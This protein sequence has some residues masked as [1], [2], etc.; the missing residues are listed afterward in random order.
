[1]DQTEHPSRKTWRD[2]Q[3][4]FWLTEE[5]ARGEGSYLLSEQA[6]A[7][8][9]DI[10]AAFCAGAWIAAIV[11][12]TAAMDA[13]LREV[14]L[15]GFAGNTKAL[16]DATTS[17]PRLHALRKRRN[18]LVHVDPEEPGITVDQQWANRPAL[19]AEARTAIELMFEVFYLSPGT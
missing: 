17:D 11:L 19:E 13:V 14:E 16:V 12:S 2:R 5:L 4:W 1:M 7:L 8:T 9:A 3:D 10:Q 6:C 18:A 15:P